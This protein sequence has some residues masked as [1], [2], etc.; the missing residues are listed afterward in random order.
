MRVGPAWA[1]CQV[2]YVGV[3]PSEAPTTEERRPGEPGARYE[4]ERIDE[5]RKGQAR[6][7]DEEEGPVCG[8][9]GNANAATQRPQPLAAAKGQGRRIRIHIRQSAPRRASLSGLFLCCC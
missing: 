1:W 9:D 4:R 7:A 3:S 8:G 2:Q 5:G 6:L